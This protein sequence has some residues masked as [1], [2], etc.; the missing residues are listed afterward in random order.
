[1]AL[2]LRETGLRKY[3]R[4]EHVWELQ[5]KEDEQSALIDVATPPRF[6][7]ADFLRADYWRHRGKLNVPKEHFIRYF[8]GPPSG[9]PAFGWAGWDHLERA[10]ALTWLIEESRSQHLIP[11]EAEVP[12][13]AGL[14]ELLPW[15][16]QWH[17]EVDPETGQSP[18]DAFA[19]YLESALIK[20]GLSQDDLR[21]WRPP[22]SRRGRPP[23]QK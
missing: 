10:Y 2:Y 23:K 3:A 12:L 7:S 8:G 13:L 5:R 21:N 16:R 4:W 6:T 22:K 17:A 9:E 14:A 19:G 11:V 15:L 20:R 1:M 18:A